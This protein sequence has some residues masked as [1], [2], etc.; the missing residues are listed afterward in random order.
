MTRLVH[1]AKFWTAVLDAGVSSLAIIL[2]FFLSPENVKQA[3]TL[4][5][6]WQPVFV[7]V[8]AGIAYEDGKEKAAAIT[9][10]YRDVSDYEPDEEPEQ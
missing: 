8:I 3:M 1:S 5:G 10:V 4:V 2:T 6:I 9:Q 7:A